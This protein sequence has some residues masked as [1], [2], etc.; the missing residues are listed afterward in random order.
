MAMKIANLIHIRRLLYGCWAR[1]PHRNWQL[2]VLLTEKQSLFAMSCS[3]EL[4][5]TNLKANSAR[6]AYLMTQIL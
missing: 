2:S 5:D 3:E 4:D 6:S 1:A